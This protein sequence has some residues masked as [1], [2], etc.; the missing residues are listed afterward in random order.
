M[1]QSANKNWK[2]RSVVSVGI[3]CFV[4]AKFS[5]NWRNDDIEDRNSILL[6]IGFVI[7]FCGY[8]IT[9]ISKIQTEVAL[10]TTEAE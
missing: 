10:L 9:L 6:R 4:D 8:P 1:V 7:F 3:D 2:C 5:G